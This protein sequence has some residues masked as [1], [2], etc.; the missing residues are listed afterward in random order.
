VLAYVVSLNKYR[1]LPVPSLCRMYGQAPLQYEDACACRNA[2]LGL[3][4]WLRLQLT[5][6]PKW[7]DVEDACGTR[8]GAPAGLVVEPETPNRGLRP[9]KSNAPL[10]LGSP[11]ETGIGLTM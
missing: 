6:E 5:W 2:V 7:P 4:L 1:C 9:Q 8:I 11:G 10:K 3:Q